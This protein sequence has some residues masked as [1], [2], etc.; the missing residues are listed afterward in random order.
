MKCFLVLCAWL[1]L[2]VLHGIGKVWGFLLFMFPS[3]SRATTLINLK[4]CFPDRNEAEISQLARQSLVNTACT[5]LEMGKAWLPA[6]GKTLA[7]VV[8]QDTAGMQ[9]L[10]AALAAKKGV[11]VL[12]PH[13]GNWE[14]FGFAVG[15]NHDAT[16]L[17]QPPKIAALDRLI[18]RARS[19]S[20]IKM[21]PTDRKGV[22]QLLKALQRGGLIGVLPDQV[23]ADESG[24]HAPF[25]GQQAFT[26]TLVSRLVQRTEARVF[27][28]FAMRL[29]RGGGFNIIVQEA[30]PSIYSENLEES[31]NGLNRS[32]EQAVEMAEAQYQW[33][34]K[35]FR[36]Q[37]DGK[38]FY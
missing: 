20:G 13:L 4:V 38:Q 24:I 26:M 7:Q 21:V 31:V 32:V 37:L 15:D 29:P 14:I 10:E 2:P 5:A 33:E 17:Y 1:P 23:P 18:R 12:A 35:R 25:F 16:F 30:D 22:A 6:I 3:R 36:R 28:G 8:A 27:C 19:R 34:Y 11:I 9:S